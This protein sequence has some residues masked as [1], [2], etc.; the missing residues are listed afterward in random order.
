MA[1]CVPMLAL[2][3]L[4]FLIAGPLGL[5]VGVIAGGFAG[6]IGQRPPAG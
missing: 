5:I 3:F 1:G 2:G 6:V 4:G